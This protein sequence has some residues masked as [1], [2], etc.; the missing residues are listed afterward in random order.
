MG[1][2]EVLVE[3]V[4]FKRLVEV[5]NLLGKDHFNE[6]GIVVL[7]VITTKKRIIVVNDWLI[8]TEYIY[9]P[10]WKFIHLGGDR[11]DVRDMESMIT[12]RYREIRNFMHRDPN[13]IN[14]IPAE[15]F[16]TEE[17]FNLPDVEGPVDRIENDY[18]IH[19][20][21]PWG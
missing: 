9:P 16:N 4:N 1:Y 11:G 21:F 2:Q 17:I 14:C 15:L 10:G 19:E 20:P 12:D 3:Y 7:S 5:F 13:K 8:R 6:R 18:A